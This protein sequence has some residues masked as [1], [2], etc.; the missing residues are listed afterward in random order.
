MI[1]FFKI[2]TKNTNMM[3]ISDWLP[4]LLSLAQAEAS[5]PQNID[6]ID[7]S[8]AIFGEEICLLMNLLFLQDLMVRFYESMN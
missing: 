1:I 8:S 2:R 5:I 7:Q 6:G 3:H 4:T